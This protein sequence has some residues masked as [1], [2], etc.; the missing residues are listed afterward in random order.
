MSMSF[1][2]FNAEYAIRPF[3][4]CVNGLPGEIYTHEQARAEAR[5]TDSPQD[6]MVSSREP[7]YLHGVAVKPGSVEQFVATDLTPESKDP[8]NPV[9]WSEIG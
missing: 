8:G 1:Q 3:I 7:T 9:P 2:C 5:S 4:G 6:Y